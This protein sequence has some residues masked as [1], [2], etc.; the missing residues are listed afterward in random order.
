MGLERSVHAYV[1]RLQLGSQSSGDEFDLGVFAKS[2]SRFR[3]GV[4]WGGIDD[5]QR[6]MR[7]DWRVRPLKENL[8]VIEIEN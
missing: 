1:K 7:S 3:I 8:N 2:F 6:F 5:Q 4:S